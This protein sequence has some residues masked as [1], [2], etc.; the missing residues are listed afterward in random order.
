MRR[1]A[2]ASVCLLLAAAACVGCVRRQL[3][4]LSRPPGATVTFDGKVLE[5]RTPVRVPFTWYGTHEIILEKEGY[6][7][8]RLVAHVRPPWYERF[9][10]D[11]F[12]EN[13]WP[14]RIADTHTYP[15]VLV[16]ER[17]L[18]DL[19]DAEKTAMKQGLLERADRFRAQARSVVGAPPPPPKTEE[20]AEKK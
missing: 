11:L 14:G 10:I 13:L 3:E 8:E 6:H 2:C 16:K 5:Q 19:S 1:T 15:L 20:K 9:P 7:R 4:I 18:K 12:S 17:P